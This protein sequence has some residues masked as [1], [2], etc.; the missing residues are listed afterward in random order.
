MWVTRFVA[1]VGFEDPASLRGKHYIQIFLAHE[2]EKYLEDRGARSPRRDR[3]CN[4]PLV[5]WRR[6][7]LV[8]VKILSLY[9]KLGASRSRDPLEKNMG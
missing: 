3:E 5:V 7:N 1:V 8:N 2:L 4:I 9:Q 6:G